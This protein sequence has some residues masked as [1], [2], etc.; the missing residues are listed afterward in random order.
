MV[1]QNRPP[2]DIINIVP[3]K[4]L[5]VVGVGRVKNGVDIV[6]VTEHDC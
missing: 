3:P 2:L 4:Q 6:V 5:Q 1:G